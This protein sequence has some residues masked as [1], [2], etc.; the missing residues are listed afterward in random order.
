MHAK[1][2]PIY[3]YI[4]LLRYYHICIPNRTNKNCYLM[5][6]ER[7]SYGARRTGNTAIPR[8]GA[9]G[10]GG[11]RHGLVTRKC[12]VTGWKSNSQTTVHDWYYLLLCQ[13]CFKFTCISYLQFCHGF[14]DAGGL[15]RIPPLVSNDA[16]GV[17]Q[18][19]KH[20]GP[21]DGWKWW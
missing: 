3:I 9:R 12:N 15:V 2:R 10:F 7:P 6:Q 20:D 8:W 16:I 5:W 1:K 11:S 4:E 14:C 19:C 17:E 18:L 13:E 21:G